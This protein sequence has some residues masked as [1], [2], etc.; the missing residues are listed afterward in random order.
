MTEV[1]GRQALERL[2]AL[3]ALCLA[4]HELL[5]G[6]APDLERAR[7]LADAIDAAIADQPSPKL[8]IEVDDECLADLR[9]EAQAVLGLH[10]LAAKALIALQ[11]RDVAAFA[12]TPITAV[13]RAVDGIR[14]YAGPSDTTP[15]FLDQRQ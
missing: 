11:A 4:Q 12:A 3:R 15:R 6:D 1:S 14:A 13:F 7:G 8:L 2:R 5:A 9:A 10:Q